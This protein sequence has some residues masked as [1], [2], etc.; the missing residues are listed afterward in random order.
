VDAR[1]GTGDW[2]EARQ[3]RLIVDKVQ[4]ESGQMPGRIFPG[5]QLIQDG[6]QTV[7][8]TERIP[9]LAK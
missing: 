5:F 8:A 3:G 2:S 9:W 6:S 4:D 7:I 1:Q